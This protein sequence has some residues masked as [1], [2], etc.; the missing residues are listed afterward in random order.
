MLLL[1]PPVQLQEELMAAADVGDPDDIADEAGDLLFAVVNVARH[2]GVDAETALRA[3]TDK[4]RRR[5][6]GVERLAALRHIDLHHADLAALDPFDAVIAVENSTVVPLQ[7]DPA[8]A[9]EPA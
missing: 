9:L 1:P 6:E 5:F 7:P 4:F 8:R 3:A 2:L